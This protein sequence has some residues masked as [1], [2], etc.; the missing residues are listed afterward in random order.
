VSRNEDKP[1]GYGVKSHP[2]L[3]SHSYYFGLA[4]NIRGF[5]NLKKYERIT[6]T[7][8][9]KLFLALGGH[10]CSGASNSYLDFENPG[11][12]A[13]KNPGRWLCCLP[14]D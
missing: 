5:Y 11:R 3:I 1:R 2:K 7:I 8:F 10:W 14:P 12:S 13:W 4:I 9:T 6:E